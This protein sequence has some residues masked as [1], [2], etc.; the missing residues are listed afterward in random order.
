MAAKLQGFGAALRNRVHT[1]MNNPCST[2]QSMQVRACMGM[3]HCLSLKTE[4]QWSDLI[5][6]FREIFPMSDFSG[7]NSRLIRNGDIVAI[8]AGFV[9]GSSSLRGI[10]YF[11]DGR[12]HHWNM[13]SEEHLMFMCMMIDFFEVCLV[14]PKKSLV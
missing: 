13:L 6:T 1:H 2:K 11:T 4:E 9:A 10:S 5:T 8:L 3:L 12:C 7:S 14:R